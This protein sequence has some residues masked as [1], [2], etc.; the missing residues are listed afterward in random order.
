M[1]AA[2][3]EFFALLMKGC[4]RI[5]PN[6]GWAII[7]F[8][9]LSKIIQIPIS[10]MVQYNSIK[11]VKMYPAMNHIRSTYFGNSD[12][13]QEENYKLYKKEKY[14]PMLDLVPVVIQLLI[15]MG[16][17]EGLKAF[18]I[19]DTIFVGIDLGHVP[20]SAGGITILIPILAALSAWFMCYIQNHV[21]VLQSEQNRIN[22]YGTLALSVGLSLYLG[23]FVRGGVGLYWIA[24]NILSVVQ[25]FILNA[26]ISPKKYID[27]EALEKSKEEL[28]KVISRQSATK[29]KMNKA[30]KSREAQ[31]Y[32]RFFKY[33]TKQIVFYSEKNGFYKYYKDVIEYILRKTDITIHYITSDIHDEVF[34][35]SSDSFRT[36]FITE[37]KLIVLMMKLDTDIMVMTMPDLQKYQIKRSLVRDDIEYIYMDHGIN[38]L[39]LVLRKHAIDY[40]DTIF[41]ANDNVYNEIKAQ[42]KAYNLKPKT[43]V[44]YGYCLIDN[45][46]KSYEEQGTENHDKP[47]VL[48]APSWQQ[49]NILDICIEP[50]LD[51]LLTG[52]YKVILR[53]HPQYIRHCND[54][55]KQIEEKYGEKGDFVLQTDFS[56]NSTVFNADVLITDWS[57]IAYEY[58]FVTLKPTLFIDTPMK[59]MNPDYQEIDVVPFDIEIRNKIGISISVN[60]VNQASETVDKLLSDNSFSKDSMLD[61]RNKYLY[62]VGTSAEIGAKYIINRLIEY[63]KR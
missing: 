20:I 14:H 36:Y 50:L 41:T 4:Y 16:V 52:S 27:Y 55:L 3:G 47:V 59:I 2:I 49:D 33:G 30:E 18:E 1:L 6:Y 43:L 44:K 13:I 40:F 9:L 39:N 48:I 26:C 11:M 25:L 8:T 17:V 38:S 19:S 35:L 21:N 7:L 32:R 46:I 37:N 12:M 10:V 63:S 34:V 53:P 51:S 15:L 57:G 31:D 22:Q 24:G 28:D 54:R 45:M 42:E 58:S 62:N 23:F 5:I 61:I 60:N 29:S 56:S